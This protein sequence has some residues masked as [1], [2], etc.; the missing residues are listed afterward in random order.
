MKT[1]L[2][3]NTQSPTGYELKVVND[4]GSTEVLPITQRAKDNPKVLKLPKNP[5]NRWWITPKPDLDEELLEYK[6]SKHFGPRTERM[7]TTTETTVKQ[8]YEYLNDE[9]KAEALK[10][11]DKAA[12]NKKVEDL[13]AQKA[14][15]E[16]LLEELEA[17][18]EKNEEEDE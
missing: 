10:L 1:Y 3:K 16:A 9:D 7:T 14:V 8:W 17:N 5:A 13:K 15:L 18:E 2:V 6:E 4:D 11:I 12:K